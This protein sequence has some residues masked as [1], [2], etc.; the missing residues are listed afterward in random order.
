TVTS[1]SFK[2]GDIPDSMAEIVNTWREKIME[3]II[4]A[5]DD[6]ME[7]YLD[8]KELTPKEIEETF[9][10][11]VKSGIVVPVIPGSATLNIGV[12][13]L[14]DIIDQSLPFPTERGKV[15]GHKVDGVEKVEF[16]A[17]DEAP[18]SALIFKTLADPFAGKL[19]LLKVMS[20]K[21]D[22]ESTI[23]NSTKKVKERLG[24]LL[25][26]EG[27]K[28]TPINTA[29]VGDI[30]AIAKLKETTTGDTFCREDNP[31]VFDPAKPFL[32]TISFAI[33]AREKE[34]EDKV[35]SS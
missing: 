22:S 27:K 31:I 4:E 7:K 35:Y 15:K 18:F 17:V 1:S 28:Q 11:G 29:N 12:G 9:I 14:L 34:N 3:N 20:G 23:F 26:I 10:E 25:S 16:D 21:I 24:Q 30:A 2:D 13:Q 19:S 5:N 32:P 33:E 8:G 6:I